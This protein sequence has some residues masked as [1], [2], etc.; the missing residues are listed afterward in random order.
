MSAVH[1][2]RDPV[3]VLAD[4]FLARRRRGETPSLAEYVERY[5]HLADEIREVF[6]ALVMMDDLDP[7][8]GELSRS[9][10][11]AG[12][13]GPLKESLRQL[14]D[15]RIVHQVGQGGMGVV[16]EAEQV[17]LGRRVALK[18]LPH[19]F[20]DA[21]Q[22]R[23]FEREAR[24]AA[25]LH[26]TNIVPVFGVGEH[27]GLPYYVMQFIQGL[28]LDVV[29]DE[30]RRLKGPGAEH[31]N[32]ACV[33]RSGVR[34][35]ELARSLFTRRAKLSGGEPAPAVTLDQQAASGADAAPPQFLPLFDAPPSGD[36]VSSSSV[37][38]PGQAGSA[39]K[40]R[41]ADY[42]H[43]VAHIGVQVAGALD[44]AHKQGILHRDI[45]PS[46]LLL[47]QRGNVWVT[48]FGLAKADDQQNL[49][50]TGDIL[51]TLR[52]MPPEAFEGKNDARGD[53]YSLGLTLFELLVMQPAYDQRDRNQLIKL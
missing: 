37:V 32:T 46:N 7:R 9:D 17:S 5:P 33:A 36:S 45:K 34:A 14:G 47:D 29:L 38:L 40:T 52:Y 41:H 10:V 1:E 6:P 15:Y 25:R 16:F 35:D 23:R 28:G 49:T 4:E 18:V 19:R 51:G 53:V 44:Y 39:A 22:K 20:M 2:E 31:K 30:L 50:H 12:G 21:K 26:H 11:S 43:S 27:D 13:N 24:A 8:S 48:D 3:E 42:W